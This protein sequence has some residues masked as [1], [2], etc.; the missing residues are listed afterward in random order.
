MDFLQNMPPWMFKA[1]AL[2]LALVVL[3]GAWLGLGR[4]YRKLTDRF[5]L[6]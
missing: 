3:A 5:P 6:E 2:A 1:L 4:L